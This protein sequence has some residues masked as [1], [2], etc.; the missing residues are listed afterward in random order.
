MAHPFRGCGF[1]VRQ[2]ESPRLWPHK[3]AFFVQSLKA[4]KACNWGISPFYEAGYL[5]IPAKRPL[6]CFQPIHPRCPMLRHIVLWKLKEPAGGL[7]KSENAQELKK[8]L[9]ALKGL[10]PDLVELKVG[11]DFRSPAPSYEICLNTL[12][13]DE[14]SLENYQQHPEHLKVVKFVKEITAERAAVDYITE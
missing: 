12:F 14:K 11:F 4:K 3:L 7:S 13:H 10:I 5:E 1:V 6:L 9:E 8:R 2:W